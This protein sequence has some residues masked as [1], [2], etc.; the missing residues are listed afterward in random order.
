MPLKSLGSWYLRLGRLG[1]AS[2]I[3][4]KERPTWA[5]VSVRLPLFVAFGHGGAT[6]L[7][8]RPALSSQSELVR[9]D[10]TVL[11]S[12]IFPIISSCKVL[13]LSLESILQMI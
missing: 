11:G 5:T 4:G 12:S 6:R 7:G 8:S 10:V 9:M 2:A 1:L 3:L 13:R